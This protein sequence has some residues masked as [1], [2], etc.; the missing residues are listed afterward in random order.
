MWAHVMLDHGRSI[1]QVTFLH[2]PTHAQWP[3]VAP[4]VLL[5]NVAMFYCLVGNYLHLEPF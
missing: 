1:V 4:F 5:L 2:L 3:M